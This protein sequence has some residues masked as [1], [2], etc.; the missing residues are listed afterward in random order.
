[1]KSTEPL[2]EMFK[3]KSGK[4]LLVSH[5]LILRGKELPKLS[6]GLEIEIGHPQ[7]K[8]IVHA[9]T[10]EMNKSELSRY[11]SVFFSKRRSDV[12]VQ[13]KTEAGLKLEFSFFKQKPRAGAHIVRNEDGYTRTE[14]GIEEV[15]IMNGCA[16]IAGEHHVE[17]DFSPADDSS[18]E[19]HAVLHNV[20]LDIRN[21]KSETQKSHEFHRKEIG[22]SNSRLSCLIGKINGYDYCIEPSNGCLFFTVKGNRLAENQNPEATLE[23]LIK[24]AA[25]VGGFEPWPFYLISKMGGR[26]TR[27]TLK[28]PDDIQSRWPTP[29][30]QHAVWQTSDHSCMIESIAGLLTPKNAE[31]EWLNRLIWIARQPCRRNVPLQVQL[32]A[33]CSAIEGI[34]KPYVLKERESNDLRFER[35]FKAAQIPWKRIGKPICDTWKRYRNPLAHGFLPY[36]SQ[37]SLNDYDEML[38]SLERLTHG[39]QLYIL[40]K[41]RYNGKARYL[42]SANRQ[43]FYTLKKSSQ[44]VLPEAIPPSQA[45]SP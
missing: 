8:L 1:M 39:L 37:P 34:R 12:V 19:V 14:F 38:D 13:G 29:L 3:S 18:F 5:R 44:F 45:E 40:R 41:A 16:L 33:A 4:A 11:K 10:S 15:R 27:H 6:I 7:A 32:L 26:V 24:G 23:G 21:G 43:K 28:I 17:D 35:M 25:F 36:A 20:R 2:V 31:T 22:L 42:N 9:V 30:P